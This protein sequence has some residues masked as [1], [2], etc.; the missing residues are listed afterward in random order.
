MIGR[1]GYLGA[2]SAGEQPGGG[3]LLQLLPVLT[4]TA[5]QL[6]DPRRQVETLRVK[7]AWAR[8][9]GLTTVADLYAARLRAAEARLGVQLESEA[10][11]TSWSQLGRTGVG[12]AIAVGA[13]L[14][15]LLLV[16]AARVR[17]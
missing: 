8:N 12:V 2:E 10:R 5:S 16:T 4:E 9:A 17:R 13:S 15:L 3:A 7:E 14:T 11:T 6:Q 1:Y